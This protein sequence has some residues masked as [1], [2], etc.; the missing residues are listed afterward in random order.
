MRLKQIRLHNWVCHKDT[1]I[2]FPKNGFILLTGPNGAGKSV[3]LEA[4]RFLFGGNVKLRGTKWSN[5]IR[6]GENEAYV[7][8]IFEHNGEII[9]IRRVVRK[10]TEG[11]NIR[12]Y[13]NGRPVPKKDIIGI[14]QK[15]IPDPDNPFIIADSN[16][17]HLLRGE[18]RM[19]YSPEG[20][21]R[22]LEQGIFVEQ[23]ILENG[24]EKRVRI[25]LES[26]RNLIDEQYSLLSEKEKRLI[27]IKA[28]LDAEKE[29][30]KVLE[31]K[32]RKLEEKR[33]LEKKLEELEGERL[34]ALIRVKNRELRK[35]KNELGKLRETE[36]ELVGKLEKVNEKF[37][38]LEEKKTALERRKREIIERKNRIE[39]QL[40]SI[41]NLISE[42]NR[43]IEE[44]NEEIKRIEGKLE[45]EKE[46]LK[47]KEAEFNRVK[48]RYEKQ[49][50]EIKKIEQK[51]RDLTR[52]LE[53]L[54]K[55]NEIINKIQIHRARRDNIKNEIRKIRVKIREAKNKLSEFNKE[56]Q[57]LQKE[58]IALQDKLLAFEEEHG[59]VGANIEQKRDLINDLMRKLRKRKKELEEKKMS[60]NEEKTKLI[61]HIRQYED[62]I[63]SLSSQERIVDEIIR[64][65]KSEYGIRAS[66]LIDTLRIIA[67]EN[68]YDIDK[69]LNALPS[70]DLVNS[71]VIEDI[72][73]VGLTLIALKDIVEKKNENI[74]IPIIVAKKSEI[75]QTL[76]DMLS[77]IKTHEDIYDALGDFG[78]TVS[79]L[80][81]P[82]ETEV[83]I[84]VIIRTIWNI[85]IIYIAWFLP[86][87]RI[88][89]LRKIIAELNNNLS[90][91][92]KEISRI[93]SEIND[94]EKREEELL[95]I[96]NSEHEL[97]RKIRE[98]WNLD[99][100]INSLKEQIESLSRAERE[101]ISEKE[102]LD[103]RIME[104][105]ANLPKDVDTITR[106][107]LDI[108]VEIRKLESEKDVASKN[109]VAIEEDLEKARKSIEKQKIKVSKLESSLQKLKAEKQ[110]LMR[111][112]KEYSS[113]I[114]PLNEKI[115]ELEREIKKLDEQIRLVQ[116]DIDKLKYDEEAALSYNL[117]KVREDINRLESR[118]QKIHDEITQLRKRAELLGPQPTVIRP[119]EEIEEEMNLI[120]IRLE[121]HFKGIDE[122][123]EIDYKETKNFVDRLER[124]LN[125][126]EAERNKILGY[127]QSM[128]NKYY[129]TLK[130]TVKILE[131]EINRVFGEA[132]INK[133]CRLHYAPPDELGNK[134]GGILVS[135]YHD[136]AEIESKTVQTLSSGEYTLWLIGL[137]VSLQRLNPS[138]L[139]I[140]DELVMH[141]DE[142][143][144][145]LAGRILQSNVGEDKVI[146]LIVP[147]KTDDIRSL[148]KFISNYRIYLLWKSQ[149]LGYTSIFTL[150]SYE[151]LR[152]LPPSG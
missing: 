118:V 95:G 23:I 60:L 2:K 59:L 150:P 4:I 35:L 84:P 1:V 18:G 138:R 89:N 149:E 122:S 11:S 67:R 101:L 96:L 119:L 31:E 135:I 100:R 80:E 140:Y 69:V 114:E 120:R 77:N 57:M 147:L 54:N 48:T 34:W 148:V 117:A 130:K 73:S 51:I 145:R 20:L 144:L 32:L 137:I 40:M 76:I 33:E 47:K 19:G 13:L 15:Y 62:E 139:Y 115:G 87:A 17:V 21:L 141:L 109:L 61:V 107:L 26:L 5:Y 3:L 108:P 126:L 56:K 37:R 9:T 143:N 39:S 10:V 103:K 28:R 91:I 111:R 152:N 124:E 129:E 22:Y 42:K 46:E 53:E 90:S 98:Q 81:L 6:E 94:I 12:Y 151:E 58:I 97:D 43:E 49:K 7:E 8:G 134:I 30:L 93:E 64:T 55:Y 70:P 85:K 44:K 24:G 146:I 105:Q 121:E 45:T 68:G 14:L 66:S 113:K 52:E 63:R 142:K 125:R 36:R 78:A 104:L 82:T 29:K 25:S 106:R 74:I 102:K 131:G 127:I 132:K 83:S 75:E 71:I 41:E 79:Y 99:M 128:K 116:I 110:D 123:L 72:A 50:S 88:A 86:Q 16:T 133:I 65:L 27:E 112:L 38:D 136:T 92:N